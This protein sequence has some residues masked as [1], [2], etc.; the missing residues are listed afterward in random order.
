MSQKL[1]PPFSFTPPNPLPMTIS[2]VPHI[3]PSNDD[4]LTA[5]ELRI[6]LALPR[7]AKATPHS[8]LFRLPN[9]DS[10]SQGYVDVSC[11]QAYST[12]SRLAATWQARLAARLGYGVGPGVTVCLMVDPY[13]HGIFHHLAF[14]ALGCT[15]QYMTVMF[16]D[17]VVDLLLKQSGC[18][19]VVYSGKTSAWARERQRRHGVEMI[20][21]PEREYAR[22]LARKEQAVLDTPPEWPT[23]KRPSP[24]VIIQSSSSTADP[25]LMSFSLYYYTIGLAWNCEQHLA[26]TSSN[27]V[28]G[29]RTHPRLIYTPPFW[30]TFHRF[31]LAHLVTATPVALVPTP[32]LCSLSGHEL[33]CWIETLDIGG[34]VSAAFNVRDIL[35]V[36]VHTELLQGLYAISMI[37]SI[38]DER[39]SDLISLKGLKVTNTLGMSE[40]GRLLYANRAPYTHLRPYPD[41]PPPL[42]VPI[43]DDPA[44]HRDK[45]SGREVQLWY[46]VDSCP[47]LAHIALCGGVPLKLEPFPGPGPAHGHL[48]MNLG[49]VFYE[50]EDKEQAGYLYVHVGR[51]DDY[52]RLS[53]DDLDINASKYEMEVRSLIE[54]GL[55]GSGSGWRLDAVQMF[56]SNLPKTALVVQLL[57]EGEGEVDE[58]VVR[59]IRRAAET[60]NDQLGLVHAGVRIDPVKRL[61]VTTPGS[62]RGGGARLG[63]GHLRLSY[64]H[65]RTLRRWQNVKIFGPW[66]E[67]LDWT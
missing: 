28:K 9:G 13:V 41:F 52:L 54:S 21:L 5:D 6:L 57:G 30:Q 15:I 18:K 16:G 55:G 47:Q 20:E 7:A 49:D 50:I 39:L 22:A 31:L 2:L 35:L 11:L 8:L 23:P 45:P 1:G 24:A 65:K 58:E 17:E 59:M 25:K 32:E 63:F 14:W 42:A 26:S 12:V 44:S 43:P 36:D 60:A 61:L 46:L 53:V 48:A 34:M 67:Q 62:R 33:A 37:G 4:P 10:P 29:P 64:T 3:G 40:L 38:V 19:A 27:A 56:G 66:L 51:I